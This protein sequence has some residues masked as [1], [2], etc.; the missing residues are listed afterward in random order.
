PH[1][2]ADRAPRDLLMSQVLTR[3]LA[4]ERRIDGE[5]KVS[6]RMRY[7]ADHRRE[8]ALWAA[9]I[10]SPHA[11]AKVR[12]V[13][14]SAAAAMPGVRA[15]ITGADVGDRRIG[16]QLLDWP[17]LAGDE[18]RFIGDRI[19]AVAAESREEAEGAAR[20]IRVDYDVLP[21]I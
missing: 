6:G 10:G 14:V 17:I 21:A 12:R 18:V 7:T 4:G 2:P 13:D 15:I 20:A 3:D 9:F 5:A 19:A 1:R 11:R 16:R 8:H